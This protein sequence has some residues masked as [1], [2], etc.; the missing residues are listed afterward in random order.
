MYGAAVGDFV[1]TNEQGHEVHEVLK[2]VL[3]SSVIKNEPD[4][5]NTDLHAEETIRH[6]EG[7][8][9]LMR[10]LRSIMWNNVGVVRTPTILNQAM[11]VLVEIREEACDLLSFWTDL[12]YHK[13][14]LP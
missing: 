7:A 11:G 6:N 3:S 10:N 13:K 8:I 12:D 9:A 4:L 2:E 14:R 5:V 1:G